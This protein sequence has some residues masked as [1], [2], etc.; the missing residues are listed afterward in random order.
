MQC[1]ECLGVFEK[2]GNALNSPIDTPEFLRL[3]AEAIVKQFHLKGCHFRL[4]SRD[5]KVLEHVAS[6][7][8]SEAFID[9]G[10]VEAERSVAEAL[11]G[12]VVAVTDCATDPR[13]QYRDAMVREGIASMLTVPLATRG[14]VIGVMRLSSATRREFTTA[15]I[16][17]LEVVASF[18]ASSVVHWMFHSILAHIADAT[19]HS[20]DL[21]AVV[22][23]IVRVV[24]QD[25]RA[26]GCAL[27]LFDAAGKRLGC[28]ASFGLSDELCRAFMSATEADQG[29]A[30][31]LRGA[32]YAVFDAC[33]DPH[34]PYRD[35]AERERV[36]SL[37]HVPLGL[38]DHVVGVVTIFT[39]HPYEFSEDELYLMK[40]IGE[41]CALAVRNA[42]TSGELR[43]EYEGLVDDFHR[44]FEEYQTY[45]RV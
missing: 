11:A 32:C 30:A 27:Q 18:C 6:F 25:L 31:A 28:E 14:Q 41:Q 22:S 26:K 5:Q 24:A 9:K 29:M 13:I 40:A 38:A 1:S 44:W 3:V 17:V 21:H 19:R 23:A 16:E 20:L 33:R 34:L 39:Y 36:G 15:E 2:I 45:P 4:L 12:R 10:P 37:L 7:G 43:R 42:Q 35:A 8:L